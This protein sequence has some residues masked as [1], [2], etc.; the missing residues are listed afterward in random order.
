MTRSTVAIQPSQPSQ[1]VQPSPASRAVRRA[2]LAGLLVSTLVGA[3][4][5]PVV[6]GGAMVGG[7][8]AVTDRRTTGTQ[9]EDQSIE[10]KA[11]ARSR[12]L[13][14]DRGQVSHTSYNRI[15]LLTGEVPSEA[16]RTAVE[17]AIGRLEN[18]R[19]VVNDLAVM[20]P[21][22]LGSRANDRLLSTKVKATFVDAKDVYANAFKVTAER[23][24]IYLMGRVTEREANTATE[25]ARS[26]SG[27]VR[28]VKVFEYITEAELA[29]LVPPAPK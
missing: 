29:T 22:S 8:L 21:S 10:L 13:L 12:E 15:V 3:G 18:V 9:L 24:V 28:V 27:V 2:A 5:V 23:G 1:P 19:G 11:I 17:Q 14:G 16:D 26:V 7:A 4:C 6:V 25:L 20:G